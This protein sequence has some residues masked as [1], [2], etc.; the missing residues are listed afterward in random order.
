MYRRVT[1]YNTVLQSLVLIHSGLPSSS[2]KLKCHVRH[3][4]KFD[5]PVLSSLCL[6]IKLVWTGPSLALNNLLKWMTMIC[7]LWSNSD[8]IIDYMKPPRALI[9][10]H[11]P[12]RM[13]IRQVLSKY[14]SLQGGLWALRIGTYANRDVYVQVWGLCNRR[15][16]KWDS[17]FGLFTRKLGG[18]RHIYSWL[19]FSAGKIKL[20]SLDKR[21]LRSVLFCF[22][23]IVWVWTTLFY[24]H[25]N[26]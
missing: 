20:R 6:N 8:F 26:K 16:C 7:C 2:Y 23:S 19:W 10:S 1:C 15:R 24:R 5:I 17:S 11:A 25:L 3:L 22:V 13:F 14:P 4:V 9:L 12:C 18:S 21:S